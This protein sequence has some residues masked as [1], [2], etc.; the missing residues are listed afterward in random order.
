M[1]IPDRL[2]LWHRRFSNFDIRPIK[3]KLLKTNVKLKCPLCAQSKI[4]NKPYTRNTNTSKHIFELLHLDLVGP[5]PESIY[6]NKYF[7]TILDDYSRY[8]WVLFLK[9]KDQ[10][11]STFYKWFNNVKIYI[12]PE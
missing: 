9:G 12:I 1:K 2:Y 10:T 3:N 6:G 5:L 4:K 8:G 11:F 7:F